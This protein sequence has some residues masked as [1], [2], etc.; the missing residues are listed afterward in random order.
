MPA[1]NN[2]FQRNANTTMVAQLIWRHN[3]VSRI[4]ISRQLKL[5]KSTVSNIISSLLEAGLVNEGEYKDACTQGGRKP[6]ELTINKDFGCVFGF[7][8]QPSHYRSVIMSVDG[9]ILWE[10]KG[11]KS[12][13]SFESF[14]NAVIDEAFHAHSSIKT[15]VLALSFSVTGQVDSERGY[16]VYSFPFNISNFNFRDF[17]HKKYPEYPVYVDNDANSVAWFDLYS[18]LDSSF[19]S[20]AFSVLADYHEEALKVSSVAGIGVGTGLIL[21]GN[22][23]R[24]SHKAAGEFCSISWKRGSS[25]QSGLDIDVLRKTISDKEALALWIEDTFSSFVPLTVVMD[26]EKIILHGNPFS[27][28]EWVRKTLEERVPSF[29]GALE[30]TGCELLFCVNDEFVS[31]K[32]AALMYLHDLYAIPDLEKTEDEKMSLDDVIDFAKEQRKKRII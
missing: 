12:Q 25:N 2:I 20:Q 19:S 27:D 5:N 16:I 1:N 13:L 15:P 23:Y 28:E 17:V 6:I 7:D 32:G 30:K 26:F 21:N 3:G 22:V 10:K 31:A 24:G 14:I 9:S 29:I 8:L 18:I 11:P 4:D